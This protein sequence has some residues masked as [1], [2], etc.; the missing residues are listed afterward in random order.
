MEQSDSDDEVAIC[1]D[2]PDCEDPA[3]ASPATASPAVTPAT[4]SPSAVLPA[5][6]S[7]VA[8]SPTSSADT[9][10][11]S[12]CIDLPDAL[13]AK[14]AAEV[15]ALM[16]GYKRRRCPYTRADAEATIRQLHASSAGYGPQPP[17]GWVLEKPYNL[18]V[19]EWSQKVSEKAERE[20]NERVAQ[21]VLAFARLQGAAAE[22]W[23]ADLKA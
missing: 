3:T 5:A 22:L 18:T 15:E 1:D 23:L 11:P 21:G 19:S 16:S 8:A 2:G 4:A 9:A 10:M 17:R 14:V 13:E 7:P 20:W 6:A 12:W